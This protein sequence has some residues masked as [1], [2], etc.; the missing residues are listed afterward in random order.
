MVPS[1]TD[2]AISQRSWSGNFRPAI[3]FGSSVLV[4]S[5]MHD[6]NASWVMVG[7]LC[8]FDR[9]LWAGRS[10]ASSWV[11]VFCW[12]LWVIICSS[13]PSNQSGS[14]VVVTGDAT[15]NSGVFFLVNS[16]VASFLPSNWLV[17]TL[18]ECA[19]S[20]GAASFSLLKIE[21]SFRNLS[22]PDSLMGGGTIPLSASVNCFAACTTASSG[23]TVGDV[24]YLCLKNI[25]SD[26]WTALESVQYAL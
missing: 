11:I 8:L 17:P 13:Y 15:I 5:W 25:V 20:V 16:L 21:V 7:V 24:I 18:G 14:F 23:V 1:R 6:N 26:P 4:I 19:P 9:V 12:F 2:P 3:V 22:S 10:S